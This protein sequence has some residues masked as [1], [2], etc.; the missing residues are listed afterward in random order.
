MKGVE[1]VMCY[2][3]ALFLMKEVVCDE[4]PLSWKL[5]LE[6]RLGEVRLWL[7]ALVF[8]GEWLKFLH[9]FARVNLHKLGL[10]RTSWFSALVTSICWPQV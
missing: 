4:L 3:L 1:L 10:K 2:A 7:E 5:G 6:G 8:R 9:L